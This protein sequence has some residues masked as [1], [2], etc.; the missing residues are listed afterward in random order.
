MKFLSSLAC[1][2][3]SISTFAQNLNMMSFNIRLSLDSDNENSWNNR[4]EDALALMTYYHPDIM[5]VQEAVP[6]QMKDIKN[7]LKGYNFVGVGR[8]DGKDK[9]EYSAIFYD[10]TKLEVL[11]SGTFWLSPTPDVPS[12]GWDAALNRICTYALFKTKKDGKKFWTF[13]LH[14]DHIGNVARVNSS[15]LILE[16][17]KSFNTKNYPIILS[18]DFNLTEDSEPIQIL[19]KSLD[20]TYYHSKTPHYGPKGTYQAFDVTVPPKDRIDYIFVKGFETLS[21]RTINDRRE[22]LLYPSDHFPIT[23]EL[24]FK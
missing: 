9:G 19:S 2:V 15:K 11:Q 8:D 18:G 21:T 6:Q 20:N 13:N 14:F 22:N 4:K 24:K 7:G 3:F 10:T 23:A 12:K 5:G 16:K 1:V 17:M